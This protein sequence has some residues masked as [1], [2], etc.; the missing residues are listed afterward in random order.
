MLFARKLRDAIPVDP[1]GLKL[2][3]EWVLTKKARELA[4]AK[5]HLVR[6]AGWDKH[7]KVLAELSPGDVVQVQNQ[8]GPHARK[9]DLSGVV[10]ES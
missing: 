3:K 9:W 4:L 7:T 1:E 8:V 2:W 5:R 10:V 6:G